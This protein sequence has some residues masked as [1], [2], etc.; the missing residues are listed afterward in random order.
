MGNTDKGSGMSNT[1][2]RTAHDLGWVEK[3]A[4][5]PVDTAPV[6]AQPAPV[7][8]TISELAKEFGVT[9]RTLR[10]YEDKG[11]LSPRRHGMTRLYGVADRDRLALI[12]KGKKLGFMLGE[13][14]QMVAAEE[15]RGDSQALK[16]SREKCLEQ[17]DLLKRQQADIEEALGE[18]RQM[19][20]SLSAKATEQ[21]AVA[22]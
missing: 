1:L 14:R 21:D 7:E 10:F 19:F 16:L 20:A 8:F 18:L 4:R 15:G 22:H 17:I 9:L 11:L 13:I 5:P 3:T 12:L 2:D 6:I